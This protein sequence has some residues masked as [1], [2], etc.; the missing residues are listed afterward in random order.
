[1]VDT[2]QGDLRTTGT[3]QRP[4]RPGR[5]ERWLLRWGPLS[6]TVAAVLVIVGFATGGSTPNDNASAGQVFRFYST[7]STGQK[8]SD[9]AGALALAF[10]VVFAAS[11]TR[12]VRTSG[13]GGW[14]ANGTVGGAVLAAA[15]FVSVLAFSLVLASDIKF[16]TAASA[17]TINVLQNDF[18]LLIV[19][20]FFVFGVV[21]GLTAVVSRAPA[22]WMGWVLF[23]FG[24]CAAVPPMTFFAVLATFLWVLV[25]SIW[26][27]VQGAPK[28]RVGEPELSLAC[29][30]QARPGRGK[31]FHSLAG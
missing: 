27:V 14:L 1:M 2:S 25:A 5:L 23:A 26:L 19:V 8:M 18:F 22:R 10:F 15:G 13:S 11:L 4:D 17:Q 7:H 3:T 30:H 6:G 28:V 31:R 29:V 9:L 16:L 24:I 21:G 20:G 12:R